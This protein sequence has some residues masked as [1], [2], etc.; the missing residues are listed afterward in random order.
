M[1]ALRTGT[2]WTLRAAPWLALAAVL[3]GSL[4]A[5]ASQQEPQDRLHAEPAITSPLDLAEGSPARQRIAFRIRTLLGPEGS[6]VAASDAMVEG[7]LDT[8][9]TLRSKAGSFTLSAQVKTD[10]L[11][12]GRLR[13][14]ADLSTRRSAGRSE[15]GLPL[16][17]EDVQRKVVELESDGT[18]SLVVLPFGRNPSG[19]ELALDLLPRLAGQPSAPAPPQIRIARV[20]PEG[21]LKIEATRSYHHFRVE[22][23]LAR[24]GKPLASG[25]GRCELAERCTLPLSAPGAPSGSKRE[26][27]ASIDLTVIRTVL[28]CPGP[29]VHLDFDLRGTHRDTEP[30]AWPAISAAAIVHGDSGIGMAGEPIVYSL[31]ERGASLPGQPDTLKITVTPE[32]LP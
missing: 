7:P 23:A 2:L 29:Q 15:R 26:A 30:Q 4:G 17:E 21:W 12:S 13:L 10:L 31:G 18:Q 32:E 28:G 14:V 3:A 8:D 19:E 25:S 22:V 16:F 20:G 11:A 5:P 27:P 9:L 6:R 24:Q 1:S